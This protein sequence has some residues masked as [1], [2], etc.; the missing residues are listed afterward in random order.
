MK[1]SVRPI[2]LP[3]P[4]CPPSAVRGMDSHSSMTGMEIAHSRHLPGAHTGVYMS[5]LQAG[6][7]T[8]Q[9]SLSPSPCC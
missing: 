5:G 7:A 3:E 8:E 4:Q 2:D 1:A 9:V 6:K